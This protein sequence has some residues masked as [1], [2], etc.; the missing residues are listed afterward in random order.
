MHYIIGTQIMIQPR[1]P[2]RPGPQGSLPRT[3]Q[4]KSG[5][6]KPGVKYTL[7]H[8]TKD[9]EGKMRYVFISSQQDDVVGLVFDS[10]TEAD[11]SISKLKQ[12]QLPDYNEIYARNTS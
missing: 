2:V 4:P 9:K 6:F 5:D 10:I 11:K 7:Y 1:T 12:E 8:I 3:R